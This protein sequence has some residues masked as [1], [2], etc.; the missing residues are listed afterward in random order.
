M[1]I[2][3]GGFDQKKSPQPSLI[4]Y[5]LIAQNAVCAIAQKAYHHNNSN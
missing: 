4:E 3:C 1:R 2:G 5:G